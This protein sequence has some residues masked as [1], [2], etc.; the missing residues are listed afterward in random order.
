MSDW[1]A[2]IGHSVLLRQQL[3]RLDPE[4]SPYTVPGEGATEEQLRLAESRIGCPLDPLYR[5]FTRRANGWKSFFT[6]AHLLGTEQLGQ[7]ELW[8]K[9]N[10]LLGLHY[11]EG[12]PRDGFPPPS[13]VTVIG[14]GTEVTDLFVMWRTGPVLNGGHQVSWLAGEEVDRYPTFRDFLLSVNQYLRNDIKKFSSAA[15]D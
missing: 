2:L 8:Q 5:D 7:G 9:G 11:S 10:E 13:E 12:P 3:T 6:Y 14:V 4:L 15:S 1:E